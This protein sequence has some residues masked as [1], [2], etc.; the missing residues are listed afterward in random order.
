MTTKQTVGPKT[1][2]AIRAEAG[3]LLAKQRNGSM[4]KA[5]RSAHMREVVRAR[6]AKLKTAKARKEALA[7]AFAASMAAR[8][9]GKRRAK[10]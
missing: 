8:G 6:W 1:A 4:T 9:K 3:K 7:P 5:E 10:V 2:A